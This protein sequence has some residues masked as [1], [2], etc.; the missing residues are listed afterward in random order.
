MV[1]KI[2]NW[3]GERLWWWRLPD[4]CSWS[5][6]V[7]A[8]PVLTVKVIKHN[9]FT[10]CV[11][12]RK[13]YSTYIMDYLTNII[14]CILVFCE[15]KANGWHPFFYNVCVMLLCLTSWHPHLICAAWCCFYLKTKKTKKKNKCR[16]KSHFWNVLRH[17]WWKSK[18]HVEWARRAGLS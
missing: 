15:S 11:Y 6:S 4:T 5:H 14:A 9:H 12:E 16:V 2:E 17:I 13:Q 3:V 1:Q 8:R 18:H 10:V 7:S